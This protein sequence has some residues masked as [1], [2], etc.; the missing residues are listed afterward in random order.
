[1][2]D[3]QE[4][5]LLLIFFYFFGVCL[6]IPDQGVLLLEESLLLMGVFL[7]SYFMIDAGLDAL[8]LL[9]EGGDR[10]NDPVQL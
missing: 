4:K 1:M 5:H 6:N 3:V 2:I 7:K 10:R 9:V 8:D